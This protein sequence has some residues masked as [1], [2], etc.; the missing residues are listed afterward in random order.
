[1]TNFIAETTIRRQDAKMSDLAFQQALADLRITGVVVLNDSYRPPWAIDVPAEPALRAALNV[2]AHVRVLPFHLVQR[3][4]FR[5]RH[6]SDD[7]QVITAGQVAIVA[8]GRA[9]R[10]A[11]GKRTTAV[12]LVDL[13]RKGSR[14]SPYRPVHHDGDTALLCGVFFLQA[15]PINP[16]LRGLPTVLPVATRGP[17]AQRMLSHAAAMLE[18]AAQRDHSAGFSTARVLEVFCAEALATQ[19]SALTGA[20]TPGYFRAM[21][22]RRIALAL[23]QV[24]SRPQAAWTVAAMA[25][26][27]AMSP[28]RFAARFRAAANQSPMAYVTHWRMTLACRQLLEH[29]H[30]GFTEVA[31][32]VGYSDVA[33]F[34]RAFKNHLGASPRAWRQQRL[35]N[36]REA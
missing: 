6:G 27:V 16:L 28:S 22:D 15:S 23:T 36:Q 7:E 4:E 11:A 12:P 33:A 9:H 31:Q 32:R 18:L 14:K 35:P 2:P 25:K 3:G 24:H 1:M 30:D 13:L 26:T 20:T 34:S 17:A 5:L 8:S 19:M 21:Q 29:P 10:M